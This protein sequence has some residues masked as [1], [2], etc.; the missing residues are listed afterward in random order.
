MPDRNGLLRAS[1][2]FWSE[3]SSFRMQ[4]ESARLKGGGAH[5]VGR[6]GATK[7]SGP[8]AKGLGGG[9][10]GGRLVVFVY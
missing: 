5:G 1:R 3:A 9:L 6:G 10:G 7:F 4:R 2:A 8:Q